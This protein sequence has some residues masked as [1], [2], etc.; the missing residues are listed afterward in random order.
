[1]TPVC[2]PSSSWRVEQGLVWRASQRSPSRRYA[3]PPGRPPSERTDFACSSCGALVRDLARPDELCSHC[4]DR[5]RERAR[6]ASRRAQGICA[7]CKRPSELSL[8]REC[9]PQQWAWRAR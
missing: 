1:M 9:R 2:L 6:Y 4:R 5:R 7:R 3:R 8:C